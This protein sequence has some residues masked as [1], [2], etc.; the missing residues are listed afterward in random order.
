[1]ASRYGSRRAGASTP[2]RTAFVIDRQGRV[3]YRDLRFN[4]LSEDAYRQLA[5][6][7]R[8]AGE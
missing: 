6:A 7:V 2:S 3:A 4:A 1:V 8:K 5:E